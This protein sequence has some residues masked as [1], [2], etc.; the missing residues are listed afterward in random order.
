MAELHQRRPVQ[1][2]AGPSGEPRSPDL[3]EREREHHVVREAVSDTYCSFHNQQLTY[4]TT[5]SISVIAV[6]PSSYWI[7]TRPA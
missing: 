7:Q 5:L 4:P 3:E 2:Q 6:K 1:P